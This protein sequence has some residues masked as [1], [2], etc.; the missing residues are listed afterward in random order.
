MKNP[1][2]MLAQFRDEGPFVKS[3]LPILGQVWFTTTQAAAVQVLKDHERFSVKKADGNVPGLSWWTPKLLTRLTSNMLSSDEPEH[4][5]LRTIVDHAFQRRAVVDME[6][7]IHQLSTAQR[8]QLFADG[9]TPDLVT[10]FARPFPLSVICELLGLPE[11]DRGKFSEWA[12]GIT[13]VSGVL[14]F[15]LA[16]RKLRPLTGY[17]QDRIVYEREHGGVGLVHEL[18]S[19]PDSD[20]TD[21]E[22]MAMVFLLLLAGHE[23]TTHLIAGG[24]FALFQ[25]PEQLSLLQNNPDKVDIAVE[26]LLRFVS[27]VQMTKPR[28][29][30][31]DCEIEGVRLQRGDLVMPLLVAANFDPAV[32]DQPERL[33][34]SRKPNRHM[35]FGTGIHFCLGHQLARME[36]KA[37]LNVLFL[38]QDPIS[39]AVGL[40]EIEWHNRPGLR[41]IKR[42][43]VRQ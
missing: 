7:L 9:A 15:L 13:T 43:P 16:I 37:A 29:V 40:E 22:L 27:P 1:A 24:A 5:R 17:I 35:E 20:L 10:G 28:F 26:E 38:G 6:P 34:L 18:V 3:K 8:Y 42:L 33:D 19:D 30:R 32:F 2:P 4:K 11:S 21:D 41:S 36:M 12:S 23:T 14:S 31:E 39:L 25:N